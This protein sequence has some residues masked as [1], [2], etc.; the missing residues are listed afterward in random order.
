MNIQRKGWVKGVSALSALFWNWQIKTK[1][2]KYR[3]RKLAD[4]MHATSDVRDVSE[5]EDV[6][7]VS[8][9]ITQFIQKER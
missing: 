8:K 4:L 6:R 2:A 1:L 7:V 9:Y 5:K 3:Q